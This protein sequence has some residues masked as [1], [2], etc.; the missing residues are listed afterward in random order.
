M[1]ICNAGERGSIPGL[2]RSPGEGNNYPLQYSCLENA[3][4]RGAWQATVHGVAKRWT[5]L[6]NWT[7]EMVWLCLSERESESHSVVSNSLWLHGLY[8]PWNSP[9]QNTGVGSCSLLQGIFPTQGSNT[10]LPH[11]RQILYQLSYLGSPRMLEWEAYPFPVDFP[12]PGIKLGSPS[13]LEDSLP[14]ELPGKPP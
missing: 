6:S 9:D 5:W 12:D 14:A 13:L 1:L 3:M 10:G 11:C 2:G 4:E 8:S 7:I